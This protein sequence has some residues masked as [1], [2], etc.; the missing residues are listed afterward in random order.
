MKMEGENYLKMTSKNQKLEATYQA[1]LETLIRGDRQRCRALVE[2]I[3]PDENSIK[4]QYVGI[5]QRLLYQ[6]G[7]LWE[8]NQL[9]VAREHMATAITENQRIW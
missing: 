2:E 8:C 1:Y 4:D 5:F 9:S 6:V 7:E 3:L